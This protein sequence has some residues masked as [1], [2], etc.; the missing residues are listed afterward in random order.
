MSLVGGITPHDLEMLM[1]TDAEIHHHEEEKAVTALSA[2]ADSLPG[3]GIV[4]AVLGVVITMGAIGGPP[5]EIGHKVA[6]LA[7]HSWEF[8]FAMDS[9][10]RWH[11]TFPN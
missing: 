4:A 3:L 7:A 11:P 2:T 1:E 9:S 6:R 8:C 5:E 10:D